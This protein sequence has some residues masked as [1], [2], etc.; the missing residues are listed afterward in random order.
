MV[1]VMSTR[2]DNLLNR[3]RE[4]PVFCPFITCGFPTHEITV[5]LLLALER[6]GAMMIELGVPFSE[7][8]ADGPIIQ[9]STHVALQNGATPEAVLN[10]V[11]KAR[12]LGLTVP[13]ILMGYLNPIIQFSAQSAEGATEARAI[14]MFVRSAREAGADGFIVVDLPPDDPIAKVFLESCKSNSMAFVPLLS[15]TTTPSRLKTLCD[16]GIGFVYAVSQLGVTGKDL[17]RSFNPLKPTVVDCHKAVKF[18][19]GLNQALD[20]PSFIGRIREVS[21]LPIAVGFG[22]RTRSDFL[23]ISEHADMC[24]IGS[25]C[26]RVINNLLPQGDDGFP[27]KI[28]EDE[29]SQYQSRLSIALESYAREITGKQN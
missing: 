9:L 16:F 5:E 22:I 14:E 17:T 26:I 6:G 23:K 11:R 1:A 27:T 12:S 4:N 21:D 19:T 8:Q 18:E 15:P 7:P 13:V 10:V 25:Q 2:L 29:I 28:P 24:V 3:E 20:L